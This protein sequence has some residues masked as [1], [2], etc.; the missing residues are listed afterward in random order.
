TI[1]GV[2]RDANLRGIPENPTADPD[3]YFPFAS[4]AQAFDVV[5][6]TPGRPEDL[7]GAAR[8]ALGATDPR[9]AV[10]DVR[11]LERLVAEQLAP[12]RFLSWLTG[13]FAV[14]AFLLALIGIYAVLAHAVRRRSHEIG[15]RAALGASRRRLFGLV[16]GQALALVGAGLGLGLVLSTAATRLLETRLFGVSAADPASYA[17]VA[18]LVLVA[19]L[20]ASAVPAFRSLRVDPMVALR[21]E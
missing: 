15:I 14:V 19:G 1:V 17:V 2:V 16:V 18:G 4:G 12:A 11:P 9:I 8:A 20:A 6:R 5:L 3:L 7:A 13:A 21:A 10:Y